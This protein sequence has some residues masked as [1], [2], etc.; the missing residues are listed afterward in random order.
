MIVLA[1]RFL[2]RRAFVLSIS[3][4]VIGLDIGASILCSSVFSIPVKSKMDQH[5]RKWMS[6]P[7]SA[8]F[9]INGYKMNDSPSSLKAN[10]QVSKVVAGYQPTDC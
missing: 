4:S 6:K 7:K 10:P 9:L 1:N 5:S 3:I 8:S 2:K